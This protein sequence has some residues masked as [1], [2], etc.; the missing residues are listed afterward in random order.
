MRLIAT[1]VTLAVFCFGVAN[2]EEFMCKICKV[3]GSKIT[4][5]KSTD[6][7]KSADVILTATDAV[8]VC[9][10]KK[11]EKTNKIEAGDAIKEGLKCDCLVKAEK[12][13]VSALVITNADG[14]ITEIR[15]CEPKKDAPKTDAPKTDAPKKE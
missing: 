2:A 3:D 9:K 12:E 8:K 13:A 11:D 7:E 4:V 1:A 14:G 6:K 10:A 15:V 5:N